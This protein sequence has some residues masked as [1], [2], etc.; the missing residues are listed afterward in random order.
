MSLAS[1][2]DVECNEKDEDS[3]FVRFLSFFCQGQSDSIMDWLKRRERERKEVI[4]LELYE[5]RR[6]RGGGGGRQREAS[7]P[8]AG[9]RDTHNPVNVRRKM[10]CPSHCL[11]D[12][13]V[14][15]WR[16]HWSLVSENRIGLALMEYKRTTRRAS[17]QSDLEVALANSSE[18]NCRVAGYLSGIVLVE[19][20]FWC[21]SCRR[22]HAGVFW[23]IQDDWISCSSLVNKTNKYER[24][25]Q[26]HQTRRRELLIG[27]TRTI[28]RDD[29]NWTFIMIDE[30]RERIE[31]PRWREQG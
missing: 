1:V 13:S 12:R 23:Q 10:T 29:A 7:L 21:W 20:F 19:L 28:K 5:R 14:W 9:C 4:K 6:R 22:D 17:S 26:D 31:K 16:C 3:L 24:E 2:A 8:D 11:L 25:C 18:S 27:Q 30:R 15:R